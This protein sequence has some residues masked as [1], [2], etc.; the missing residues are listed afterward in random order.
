VP[1]KYLNRIEKEDPKILTEWL[2]KH[3]VSSGRLAKVDEVANLI[4]FLIS[5]HS[6]YMHGSIVE[7]DGGTN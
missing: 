2:K 5:D 7:I 4:L 1:G 6:S 3:N